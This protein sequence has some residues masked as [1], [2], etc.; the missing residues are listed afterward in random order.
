VN[1]A[2]RKPLPEF[3]APPLAEVSL[4][5]QFQPL[6]RLRT[7]QLGLLWEHFR[8]GLPII[9]EHP[10]LEPIR[11]R[12]EH[13]LTLA[14]NWDS[15]GGRSIDPMTVAHTVRVL[16]EVMENQSPLPTLVPT[17]SGG[18]QIEWHQG[19]V[20]LEIE[21]V[22]PSTVVVDFADLVTGESW[23]EEVTT[24]FRR[25]KEAVQVVSRRS[26]PRSP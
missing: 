4:G 13:L 1:E 11:D 25:V 23:E 2:S 9:E 22:S 14:Q 19:R 8:E 5:V 24:D 16:A 20:D 15:Y 3:D 10:P 7:P 26:M 18:V 21:V 6:E 12:V 17:H